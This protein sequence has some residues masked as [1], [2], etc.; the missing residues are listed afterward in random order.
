MRLRRGWAG[1]SARYGS[2]APRAP[3]RTG[4]QIEKDQHNSG[5]SK[6]R[7]VIG[8]VG[9]TGPGAPKGGGEDDD[10]QEKDGAHDF[11]PEHAA[12]AAEGAQKA[13]HASRDAPRSL[14]G[15]LTGLAALA[16]SGGGWT[17]GRAA[18]GRG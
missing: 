9:V 6:E 2:P 15:N 11:K 4:A 1:S 12:H 18:I 7:P 16:G 5:G 17:G 13:A 10:G 3:E 8:A 14:A